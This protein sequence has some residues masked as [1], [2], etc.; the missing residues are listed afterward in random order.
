MSPVPLALDD[1]ENQILNVH[2]RISIGMH[3]NPHFITAATTVMMDSFSFVY[4]A[5]IDGND[6]SFV[7]GVRVNY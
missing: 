7:I 6:E 5:F 2:F 4:L 1:I 3:T